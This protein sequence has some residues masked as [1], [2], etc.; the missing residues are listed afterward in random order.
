MSL[1]IGFCISICC[2]W[3]RQKKNSDLIYFRNA[4]AMVLRLFFNSKPATYRIS[5]EIQNVQIRY[6]FK[7]VTFP[8]SY[9]SS[10]HSTKRIPVRSNH[11]QH[12]A[13]KTVKL[14]LTKVKQSNYTQKYRKLTNNWNRAAE[15]CREIWCPDS[16]QISKAGLGYNTLLHSHRNEANKRNCRIYPINARSIGRMIDDLQLVDKENK[17]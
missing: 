4:G 14:T 2:F 1:T 11:N 3:T 8:S 10:S 6:G 15:E 12:L 13:C 9:S 17:N 5:V 16:M 7:S